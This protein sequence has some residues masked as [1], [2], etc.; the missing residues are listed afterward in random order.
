MWNGPPHSSYFGYGWMRRYL[1]KLGEF[2]SSKSQMKIAIVRPT[3]IYGRW[4]NFS[5][6]SSHVIPALIRRA[7]EKEN[8]YVVWG[9]GNEIRDFLHVSDLARACLLMLEKYPNCDPAI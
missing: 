6:L 2:I 5:P 4:D 9:T 3:A 7:V 8:P 1:E